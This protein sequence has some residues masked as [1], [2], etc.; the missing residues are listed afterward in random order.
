MKNLFDY[1]TKELSQ[2]AFLRWLFE[3]YQCENKSVRH[4]GRRLFDVF[5]N[6]RFIGKEITHLETV[7]Q[8][9]SIDIS[10][11]FEIDGKERL[12]VIE[13]KTGSGI[14]DSQL[15]KYADSIKEHDV[16]WRKTENRKKY[17]NHPRYTENDDDVFM[18]FYKTNIVDA[19]ERKEAEDCGWQVYDIYR[20]NEI[21]EDLTSDNEVLC[22]YLEHIRKMRICAERRMPPSSWDLMSWHSFFASYHVPDCVSEHTEINCYQKKYYYIKLFVKGHEGDVPCLEIRSRDVIPDK[23]GDRFSITV[24]AV[25]YNLS[26]PASAE[27]ISHWQKLLEKHGFTLN[28]RKNVSRHK[29]IGVIRINSIENNEQALTNAL[30]EAGKLLS[31]VFG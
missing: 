10:V 28:Y 19:W 12:I 16:F 13:D 20:I 24:R 8:W 1:T 4:A 31:R 29:Q 3:N 5:T 17:P 14:H 27:I 11:R 22:Y 30:N 15:A 9:K 2:D 18:I 7:A 6:N 23:N 26:D 21:F 25:L